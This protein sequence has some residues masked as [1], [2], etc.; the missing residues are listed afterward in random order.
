MDIALVRDMLDTLL[1]DRDGE[2]MGRVDGLVMSWRPDAAPRITH[3][4]LGGATLAR[5]LPR[6]FRAITDWLVGKLSPRT[7]D[8]YRIEVARI[9]HLGRNIE[10]D[11]DATRSAARAT[12]RWVRDHIVDRIPW[13]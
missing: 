11:I 3:M 8:P 12:E 2:P 13:S 1:I 6:P 4:E 9:V 10:V 5:R 7:G